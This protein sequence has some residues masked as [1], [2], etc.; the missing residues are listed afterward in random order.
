MLDVYVKPLVA[1]LIMAI[2]G[3]VFFH[4]A[5]FIDYRK[6]NAFRKPDMKI[7]N[8]RPMYLNQ[9]EDVINEQQQVMND[10]GAQNY[11]VK[12]KNL[13]KVYETGYPAVSDTTFGIKEN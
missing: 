5:V 12:V 13:H 6:V 9:D 3:F 7:P 2:E 10:G 1:C 11:Q 8:G 4:I